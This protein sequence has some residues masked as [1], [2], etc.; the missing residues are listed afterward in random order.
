MA[1]MAIYSSTTLTKGD[2]MLKVAYWVTLVFSFAWTL[3]WSFAGIV[4]VIGMW[5]SYK[6]PMEMIEWDFVVMAFI[7]WSV[8]PMMMYLNRRIKRLG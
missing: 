3:M 4:L 5:L 6:N 7:L 8:G 2:N 1:F